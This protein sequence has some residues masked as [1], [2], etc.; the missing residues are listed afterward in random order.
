MNDAQKNAHARLYDALEGFQS[1]DVVLVGDF[2]LDQQICG[3]AE[4]LSP[5]APVPI[6]RAHSQS[7]ITSTPGGASNVAACL[8]ALGAQVRCV[9]VVGDDTEGTALCAGLVERNCDVEG[10][11]VDASRPTTVKRSLIGLAQ[12]RHPQKMFRLDFESS[13]PL[14][15]DMEN[16][17]LDAFDAALKTARVVC[18]ED[19]GKGV[20][21]ERVCAHVIARAREHNIPVL[22]DPAA[23][24]DYGRYKGASVIT[25]NRSEAE[26]ATR[27]VPPSVS[28][29]EHGEALARAL[30]AQICGD[31]IVVTLDRDGAILLEGA[32]EPVHVPT[33]ARTVYDVTGAGDMVLSAISAGIANGLSLVD[34]V[35]L[36]NVAAGLEV[37]TFGVRPIPL[38]EL[39]HELLGRV[40]GSCPPLR[41]LVELVPELVQHREEGRRIVLTNGCFDV[42]HAGHVAYLRE[43]KQA[44]DILVVGVNSDEQVR[45]LKG[46]QRPIFNEQERL[47]ILGELKCIDYLVVFPEKTAHTLIQTVAPDVYVKGGDYEPSAIAEYELLVELGI[48]VRV[49]AHRPGLGS[50]DLIERIRSEA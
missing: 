1:F 48:D 21:T 44:G 28:G 6:L 34:S 19:Y 45:A 7:D 24:E 40:P 31:A 22:V 36:A 38:T 30:H 15:A 17:L 8:G 10:V 11:V 3:A 16:Q 23:R 42:I 9:G 13:E 33:S 47:E 14:S 20:C 27:T 4:R 43:A 39:K 37:E 18:L 41:T 25:P 12:H 26:L 49:L 35:Q 2:M 29:L 50:S 5:E 46:P 32:E